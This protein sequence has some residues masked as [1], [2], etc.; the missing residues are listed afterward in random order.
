MECPS[1]EKYVA[2]GCDLSRKKKGMMCL[3]SVSCH[4]GGLFTMSL[5]C[6]LWRYGEK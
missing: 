6:V 3:V 1:V 5:T 4:I 2:F